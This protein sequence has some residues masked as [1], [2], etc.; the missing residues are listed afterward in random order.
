MRKAK[1]NLTLLRYPS[2][3]REGQKGRVSDKKD[4]ESGIHGQSLTG[5]RPELVPGSSNSSHRKATD[6]RWTK[7]IGVVIGPK[8]AL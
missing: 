7:P 5:Q 1:A 3:L 8:R 4:L 6:P 2:W